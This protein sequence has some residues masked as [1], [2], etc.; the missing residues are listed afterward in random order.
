MIHEAEGLRPPSLRPLARSKA[1]LPPTHKH[2]HV[3]LQGI[4]ASHGPAAWRVLRTLSVVLDPCPLSPRRAFALEVRISLRGPAHLPFC[5]A[6]SLRE[7]RGA[8]YRALC[9][10]NMFGL[11]DEVARKCLAVGFKHKRT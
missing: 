1:C 3:H 2:L 10:L 4:P 8:E 6:A 9:T 7:G 11:W 5:E